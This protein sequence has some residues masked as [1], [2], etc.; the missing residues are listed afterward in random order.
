[1]FSVD[2]LHFAASTYLM[3]SPRCSTMDRIREA[4]YGCFRCGCLKKKVCFACFAALRCLRLMSS[5][6]G[7]RELPGG[8]LKRSR[9]KCPEGPLS[10]LF[11]VNMLPDSPQGFSPNVYT[12]TKYTLVTF[13]PKNIYHQFRR[14][15]NI[16]F[17]TV[18]IITLIPAVSPIMY[19]SYVIV[20]LLS[21]SQPLHFRHP[22]GVRADGF[23]SARGL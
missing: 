18:V 19:D 16:F 14:F 22:A 2:F 13:I 9:G 1:M 15:T 3:A 10:W 21:H 7:A 12:T 4:L 6:A 8:Q 20:R 5:V 11:Y 23:C 17:L